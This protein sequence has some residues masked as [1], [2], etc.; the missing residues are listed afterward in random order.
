MKALQRHTANPK[1]AMKKSG[2]SEAKA[3]HISSGHSGCRKV[4]MKKSANLN[5]GNPKATN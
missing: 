5:T 3:A 1:K 2:L 4:S